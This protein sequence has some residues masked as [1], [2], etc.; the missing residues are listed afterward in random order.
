MQPGQA[1]T[2]LN[3]RIRLINKVNTDVADWLQV[4]SLL[5]L[6]QDSIHGT[7][8]TYGLIVCDR[9]DDE[10]KKR[11]RRVCESLLLGRSWI[12]APRSGRSGVKISLQIAGTMLMVVL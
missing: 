7:V 9:N 10:W 11:M 2:L 5:L 3:D 6:G 12:T 8:G 1:T 4:R